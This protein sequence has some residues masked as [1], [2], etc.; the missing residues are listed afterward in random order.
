[1][2][3]CCPGG[4]A[5]A[6]A[7]LAPGDARS[8]GRARADQRHAA[9][10]RRAALALLGAER[11]ARAADIAAALSIDALRGSFHPFEARIHDAAAVRRPA[12]LGRQPPRCCSRAAPSTSRTSTA[13]GCRTPTRCA[14]RRRCTARRATRCDFVARTLAIEAN[15]AT[16]NPMVFADDGRHRLG[17][18]LPRRAG[19]A[20][21]RPAGDR[22]WCSS[23]RSA[24]GAPIGSSTRRSAACRRS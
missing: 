23:R 22:A 13:A 11:L 24:S 3:A 21:R 1:M 9:L 18:Q 4:D 19:G 17:R 14:A 5:L 10:D 8:E 6:R 2:T 16:D 20:R 15:A 12:H 7:G